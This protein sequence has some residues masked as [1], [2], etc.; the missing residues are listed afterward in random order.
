[1][2][3]TARPMP[4]RVSIYITSFRRHGAETTALIRSWGQYRQQNAF[5]S[6][7]EPHDGGNA[8]SAYLASIQRSAS[9]TS[10]RMD[11]ILVSHVVEPNALRS[12]D[13]QTFFTVRQSALLTRVEEAMGKSAAW[14]LNEL[15]DFEPV[16]DEDEAA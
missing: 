7:N 2:A 14:E 16:E 8:P 4:K 13:F 6:S 3:S 11:E 1:M 9:I 5:V 12:D 15:E 10:D